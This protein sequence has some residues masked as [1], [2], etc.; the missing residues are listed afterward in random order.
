MEKAHIRNAIALT[1]GK[2]GGR[3][4]ASALLGLKRT[5]LINRM[6]RL[7]ITVEKSV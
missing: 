5:T 2:I 6:K 1:N 3:E 4:G 7:G